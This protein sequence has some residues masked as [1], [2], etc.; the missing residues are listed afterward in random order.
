[1]LLPSRG[2]G[3]S[4]QRGTRQAGN[5]FHSPPAQPLIFPSSG[6]KTLPLPTLR[7][8][9]NMDLVRTNGCPEKW[10]SPSKRLP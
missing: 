4:R 1:M 3:G 8:N 2:S 6:E 10:F 7:S 9:K 5:E